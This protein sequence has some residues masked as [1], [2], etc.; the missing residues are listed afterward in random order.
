MYVY[1][2]RYSS[3]SGSSG[4]APTGPAGGTLGRPGRRLGRSGRRCCCRC[5]CRCM[6]SFDKY[7][8]HIIDKKLNHFLL[9][10]DKT[11]EQISFPQKVN[12][13]LRRYDLVIQN[14]VFFVDK[15]DLCKE[16]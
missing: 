10:C 11:F 8:I 15:Y 16:Y 13:L 4:D 6:L 12:Y 14:Y 1:V 2:T 3:S 9:K 7:Y 5:Y